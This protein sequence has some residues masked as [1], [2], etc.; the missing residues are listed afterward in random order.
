M[1]G[2]GESIYAAIIE[3]FFEEPTFTFSYVLSVPESGKCAIIDP[4]LD[5]DLKSGRT[6]TEAADCITA[7]LADNGP[8]AESILETHA[9][10]DHLSGASCLRERLDAP[11]GIGEHVKEVQTTLKNVFNAEPGFATDGSQ[12]DRLFQDGETISVGGLNL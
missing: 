9:H 10:A 7:F 8:A 6:S 11:I 3:A 5:F 1:L 12:F 2:G 4:L